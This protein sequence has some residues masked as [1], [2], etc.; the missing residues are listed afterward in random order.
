MRAFFTGV[1]QLLLLYYPPHPIII[2]H[3]RGAVALPPPKELPDDVATSLIS[4]HQT[5]A[6]NSSIV[7]HL[8]LLKKNP[9]MMGSKS[10]TN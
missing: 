7:L 2:L 1:L 9:M 10:M 4:A 8:S 3:T 5:Q 6:H